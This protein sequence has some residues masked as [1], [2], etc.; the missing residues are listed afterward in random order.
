MKIKPPLLKE[1]V[2]C[3]LYIFIPPYIQLCINWY[4]D[5]Q[6]KIIIYDE[7]NTCFHNNFTRLIVIIYLIRCF[8]TININ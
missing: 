8:N 5:Y 7:K 4:L 1:E 2:M 3:T 6:R